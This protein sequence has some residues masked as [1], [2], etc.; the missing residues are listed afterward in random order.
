MHTLK[1]R[2]ANNLIAI[3]GFFLLLFLLLKISWT[4]KSIW[5][6]QADPEYLTQILLKPSN[7]TIWFVQSWNFCMHMRIHKKPWWKKIFFNQT[8]LI[9]PWEETFLELISIAAKHVTSSGLLLQNTSLDSYPLITKKN[10]LDT[11]KKSLW[12]EY[13]EGEAI[14]LL[15]YD[16][17][18]IFKKSGISLNISI[19][20][21]LDQIF[22][23]ECEH[24]K[25]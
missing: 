14:S 19:I 17:V 25:C 4:I 23:F 5:V 8:N 13:Q 6:D 16:H 10:G 7:H 22:L 2:A 12:N 24:R 9:N 15:L 11:I 3:S 18:K 1:R 21:S 20:A